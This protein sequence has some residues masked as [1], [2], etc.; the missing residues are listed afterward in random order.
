MGNSR[1]ILLS[2]D[3]MVLDMAY[4]PRDMMDRGLERHS[5]FQHHAEA[6]D[7]ETLAVPRRLALILKAKRA[8]MRVFAWDSSKGIATLAKFCQPSRIRRVM[9]AGWGNSF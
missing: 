4:E 1:G 9:H 5:R 7:E 3:T 2:D 6:R 8:G